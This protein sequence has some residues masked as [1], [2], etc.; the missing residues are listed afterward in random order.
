[1]RET[2]H[3]WPQFLPDG[4]HFLYLARS[5]DLEK[6][7]IYVQ[8]IGSPQ[9]TLVLKSILRALYVLPG[10]L[11]F[12]REGTLFAQNIHPKRF[13]LSGEPIAVAGD[14]NYVERT[15]RTGF[16]VSENGVL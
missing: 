1:R 5:P 7:G 14:V 6:N 13:Q 15:G 2:S 10:Y 12:V 16:T 4:K 11:L 9:K 8:E 3:I